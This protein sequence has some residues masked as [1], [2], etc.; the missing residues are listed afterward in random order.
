MSETPH[1]G[2]VPSSEPGED[3][4]GAGEPGASDAAYAGDT[5]DEVVTP[6]PAPEPAPEPSPEDDG[7]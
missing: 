5:A 7:A 1:E 3:Y 4:T 2:T 6:D